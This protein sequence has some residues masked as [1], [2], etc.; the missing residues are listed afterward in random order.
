M[1]VGS[2]AAHLAWQ[3]GTAD[4]NSRG[5]LA[6]RFNSSKW[7]GALLLAGIVLGRLCSEPAADEES[8]PTVAETL[9]G[10]GAQLPLGVQGLIR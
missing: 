4:Y 10:S 7:V 3:A 2:A 1:A 9:N 6:H 5:S 8:A